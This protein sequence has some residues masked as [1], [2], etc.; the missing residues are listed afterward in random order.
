MKPTSIFPPAVRGALNVNWLVDGTPNTES[1]P[2]VLP[3]HRPIPPATAG[4]GT[5]ARRSCP[6][7][8]SAVQ[9][10][11]K[12]EYVA[13]KPVPDMRVNVAA[14]IV[15]SPCAFPVQ[16]T[17]SGDER[18]M[19]FAM[20]LSLVQE[21]SPGTVA[22]GREGTHIGSALAR[23]GVRACRQRRASGGADSQQ[24]GGV[25]R[26]KVALVGLLRDRHVRSVGAVER[27]LRTGIQVLRL[28]PAGDELI[29]GPACAGRRSR[30]LVAAWPGPRRRL[31]RPRTCRTSRRRCRYSRSRSRCRSWRIC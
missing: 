12:A 10:N 29:D 26:R 5:T 6:A 27:Q 13:L 15:T 8:A 3:W 28:L 4:E 22:G 9:L 16:L 24:A 18:G 2:K 20:T 19:G 23:H 14:K 21:K 11:P 17:V 31:N 25:E 1:V 30:H 7:E